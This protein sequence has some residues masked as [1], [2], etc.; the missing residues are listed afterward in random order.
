M[1]AGFVNEGI[2]SLISAS[3]TLGLSIVDLLEL[4]VSDC[5]IIATDII[6][7]L[8]IFISGRMFKRVVS[9]EILA[10]SR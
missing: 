2:E 5:I 10:R 3:D 4:S 8:S 9:M 1:M 7:S 6:L